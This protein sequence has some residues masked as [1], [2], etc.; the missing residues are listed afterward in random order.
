MTTRDIQLALHSYLGQA[1]LASNQQDL[2]RNLEAFT[3]DWKQEPTLEQFDTAL[4]L[5]RDSRGSPRSETVSLWWMGFLQD[6][7]LSD[8]IE[9]YSA[10]LRAGMER[11]GSE[12]WT[13]RFRYHRSSPGMLDPTLITHSLAKFGRSTRG[14]GLGA[15]GDGDQARPSSLRHDLPYSLPDLVRNG[16]AFDFASVV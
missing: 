7:V 13:I 2:T 1:S 9:T 15:I 8:H 10:E 5:L 14:H 16:V 12:E 4:G 6:V 3:R 11:I